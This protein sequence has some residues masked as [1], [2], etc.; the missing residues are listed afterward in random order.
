MLGKQ[1]M[2]Y[3]CTL[4]FK[5]TQKYIGLAGQCLLVRRNSVKSQMYTVYSL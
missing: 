2:Q 3:I 4:H 5:N 1:Y